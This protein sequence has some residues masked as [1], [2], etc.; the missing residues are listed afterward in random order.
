MDIVFLAA[1]VLA[2]CVWVG[3]TV[4]LV[5]VAVPYART[6]PGGDRVKALRALGRG[7]RLWG[8]GA[9]VVAVITGIRLAAAD[10]AFNGAGGDFD[11]VLA[12][13]IA[14]VCL[15]VSG[16]VLHDF[17][18]GPLLARQ[19]RERRP[20]TARRPLVVIGWVNLALT[21]TVPVLGAALVHLS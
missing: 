13:K 16:A 15:L 17:V 6:L 1:H 3:G 20:Q 18:L 14:V 21:V 10:D 11:T 19:A 12:V 5:F 7:W 9:M 8:W 2:A 4:M